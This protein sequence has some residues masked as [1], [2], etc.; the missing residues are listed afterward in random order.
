MF[1]PSIGLGLTQLLKTIVLIT[2][3]QRY[4]KHSFAGYLLP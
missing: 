1:A 3:L 2:H 4:E